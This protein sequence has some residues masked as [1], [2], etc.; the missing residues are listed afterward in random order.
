MYA[1]STSFSGSSFV[2][3]NRGSVESIAHSNVF[4]NNRGQTAMS[5]ILTNKSEVEALLRSRQAGKKIPQ[6]ICYWAN[7]TVT[8]VDSCA[9]V[10]EAARRRVVYQSDRMF[11]NTSRGILGYLIPHGIFYPTGGVWVV[12]GGGCPVCGNIGVAYREDDP[13][14][15]GYCPYGC[16]GDMTEQDRLFLVLQ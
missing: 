15:K 13:E 12:P 16:M 10:L 1:A 4:P 14:G 3:K 5:K 6:Y 8:E 9:P 7:G 2:K 11:D